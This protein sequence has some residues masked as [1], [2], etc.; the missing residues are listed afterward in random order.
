MIPDFGAD[1]ASVLQRA[2]KRPMILVSAADDQKMCACPSAFAGTTV[3]GSA[4]ERYRNCA[5]IAILS[6]T[7]HTEAIFDPVNS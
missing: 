7:D 4:R 3:E 5:S 2:L 1:L 6:I